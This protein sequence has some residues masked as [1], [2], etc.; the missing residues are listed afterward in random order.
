MCISTILFFTMVSNIFI[1][2]GS[3]GGVDNYVGVGSCT[4]NFLIFLAVDN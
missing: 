2:D 4:I 1:K 3:A